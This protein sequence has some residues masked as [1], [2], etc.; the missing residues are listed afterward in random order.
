MIKIIISVS[1]F[2]LTCSVSVAQNKYSDS[3]KR[4]LVLAKDDTGRA[5]LMS[6]LAYYYRFSNLDSSAFYANSALALAEQIKFLRGKANALDILG[7][8]MREKGD[9]PKS[10]DLQL[11]AL[12]IAEDNNFPIE[13][14][15]CLRRIGLVY[16]DLKDFSRTISYF[17]AA[18]K[19]S[20]LINDKRGEVI[21]YST[22]ADAYRQREESDSADV[23]R[24][25]HDSD[26][27]L[28][29]GQK[30]LENITYIEDFA[31]DVYR[32]FGDIQVMRG[33]NQSA[34]SSY[35][36][37]IRLGLLLN[38]FRAISLIYG[39]MAAFYNKMDRPDSSI[40]FATNGL[41]YAQI[42]SFKL[43]I[44][45][46]ARLLSELYDST[47]PKEALRYD[48]IAAA[49]KDSLFGAGNITT[50]QE[51]INRENE[52]QKEADAADAAYR[53]RLKQYG[54]L[55][56]LA[57][58]F[59]IAILLYR[60]NRHKQKANL[61]L[62]QQKK[63]VETTLE[64][65][66]VAKGQLEN[67]NRDLEIEAALERVRSRS[68]GM[69]K[70]VE[71]REVVAVVFQQMQ[72]LGFNLNLCNILL[73]NETTLDI[74]YWL[75]FHDQEVLPES[76]HIPYFDH[77]VYHY[78]LNAWKDAKSF[79]EFEVSGVLKTSWDEYLT[80]QTDI[81]K[82][83]GS[84]KDTVAKLEKVILSSVATTSGLLL[85]VS[86]EPLSN[87]S[88]SILQRF[89][90]VFDQSYT[91]FLD[92]Q[93]AEAQAREAKIEAALEKVRS[94][95]MAMQRSAE[96]AEVATVL[97]RQVKALGVSQWTCGFC[98]WE[99]DD[100]EFIWY[101]GSDDGK[102]LE[103]SRVPL[104]GHPIFRNWVE[105]RK[106]GDEL[107][108]YE[109]KGEVQAD[110]YRY[111][112]TVPG[113]RESLQDMLDAGFTFP[114]FQID[115]VANFSHGNLLFITYEHFPEMHDVFKRFAKVFDQTYTR[116]LDLQKAEAQAR[117][118]QIETSLERVRAKAMAMHNSNDLSVTASM[119]FTELRK[120]GINPI[121]SGVGLLTKESSRAQLYSAASSPDGDTLSMIGWIDMS[122]HPI[123]ED[124][125][126]A[127]LKNEDW[128]AVLS[129]EQLKSYYEHLSKGL[130]IPFPHD[131][132]E[133][134]KE[135][136]YFIV[137]SIG[138]LSVWSET[139]YNDAEIKIL[140]RFAA[141]IDLTFRR[142]MELQKSE[143][144]AREA[145]KQAALDRIRADIASMRTVGDLDRI[146]PLIWDELTTLGIPFIRCGVFIMDD[147]QK[148][149]H[150]FLSTPDGKAIAAFHLP[151][152]SPSFPD[153]VNH[154][155]QKTIYV[156]HWD[157]SDFANLAD[158]LVQQGAF[159]SRDQ[160]LNT[161]PHEGIHLHLLPFLQGMLYVGNTARLD[162][163]Q[164]ELI[165]SVADA[166]STAYAR[167]EDFNKLEAAKRQTEIA[168]T[169][170]KQAQTQL[171]QSEK[172]ASLGLLTAGIA[173]E[174][175]N[176]LNFVNNFSEVNKELV[177]ELQNELRSG[178]TEEAIDISNDI[179]DNEEKINQHGKRAD[180]IVKGM[181]Q[182]SRA[183]SGQTELTDINK[184]A[185]EY[186][187]LS[188]HGMRA[189]DK[190]FNAEFKTDFDENIGK[191][192]VVP[193]DIGRVLL[194]LYNNA[195]YTVN[196]RAKLRVAS[197]ESRVIVQ[198][199]KLNDKVE[200]IVKDNGNGIPQNI[201]DKIFQPFFTT[202]PTGQ[203]TGLGLSLAYDIIKAHGGKIKVQT[204]EGEG[205][206]F[207]IQFLLNQAQ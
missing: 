85:A 41:K 126:R 179:K 88:V 187:R 45:Q 77:P 83:S 148:L 186:L 28:Y 176:P 43:G 5:L 51:I 165:Q 181:L 145:V 182:H 207:I 128:L 10:L 173:H 147:A 57:V 86:T 101:P 22:L 112:M 98:I 9:L 2:A 203:G 39:N 68:M 171:I 108:I 131:L 54:L 31:P 13:K 47:D 121:R 94:R 16:L 87:E 97:F 93:K 72:K 197:Y 159:A 125:F 157:R 100:K 76:Y 118:A 195:F 104:T 174:I 114:T 42:N 167:Y 37:G 122:G 102:I 116:F 117:E 161:L 144:S 70:S 36:E 25:K 140:K 132:Y 172:M 158:T 205:S 106:R 189:K 123:F 32:T 27:A 20:L 82:I 38:D 175:Q 80:T 184:L 14:S 19:N 40:Y 15:N 146:T 33:N 73:I 151:Y 155:K 200:I 3:L 107:Y 120:L 75:S 162:E 71:L 60:N 34:L 23:Y 4:E 96:L 188:Y 110:H 169:E 138:G 59:L 53:N 95:T 111:M 190:G 29:Y 92:L 156:G 69:Q 63:K 178:N 193:Q 7:L 1:L 91:R 109:K 134:R 113:L 55:A 62:Q 139:P 204:R 124:I 206:E 135:Y 185:D 89:A 6:D 130:N 84:I 163:E 196:E 99:P 56:G 35:R 103:S 74:D 154:W 137:T 142:Y 18:L 183:S 48:K 191:I 67:T 12:K 81:K 8:V 143:A 105:A 160:Y 199:K 198:T 49:A 30:A 129:S 177:D 141:I 46:S 115:H 52:R 180:S 21:E 127:W 11:S 201:V 168:L 50:I 153:I 64:E 61:L 202:K 136:G 90:K 24:Q 44:L 17:Q 150:T 149:S 164:I 152:T 192:N 119:V 166:F 66:K 194:N 65:L 170:L 133:G 78:Q 26:S 79:A 58:V